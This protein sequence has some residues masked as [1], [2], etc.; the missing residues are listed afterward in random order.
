[1]N[2]IQRIKALFDLL[3][4]VIAAIKAIEALLPEANKGAD[5]LELIRTVAVGTDA[6]ITKNWPMVESIIA[7][8][9]S[10][11]N[12]FGIFKTTKKL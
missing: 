10:F 7:S 8:V 11:C 4:A 3:P 6:E 5:K 12:K 2:W 1:M 9:V